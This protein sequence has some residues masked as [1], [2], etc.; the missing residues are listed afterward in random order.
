MYFSLNSLPG[1]GAMWLT[2]IA[3]ARPLVVWLCLIA[4]MLVGIVS[5]YQLPVELN[6]R[7]T[8]PTITVV[9]AYPGAGPSEVEK[10][11]SKPIEDVVRGLNGVK[12]IYSSS[13][14]NI[15][16]VS[17]DF[18]VGTDIPS[19][20]RDLQSRIDTL[21]SQFPTSVQY[22]VVA[23]LDINTQP[24][25]TLGVSSS[26]L[27]V[28]QL[29]MLVKK[30]VVPKLQ[31]IQ[32]IGKIT[33]LGGAD[34]EVSVSVSPNSLAQN[35]LTI[36]DV[37]NSLDA[38]GIN[39]P[40][41]NIN[42]GEATTD[43][44]MQD[45][46][47]S[48]SQINEAPVF[49]QSLA[50]S[51][52]ASLM[53]PTPT[54]AE[55]PAPPL[56]VGDLAR[57]SLSWGKPASIVAIDGKPGISIVISKSS[58]S[59]AVEVADNV[60]KVMNSI[61]PSLHNQATI[62][63]LNNSTTIVRAAL[64]DVDFSLI[65]GALLSMGVVY[66]FL[67]NARG[68]VIV[69][70]AI[71]ACVAATFTMMQV[72]HLTL[73]QMTLLALSL[74]VGILIDDSIVVLEA[75]TRHLN[76]G[77]SP[78]TAALNG[79]QEIGFAGMTITLV[80]VVVFI[81]IA[82]MGGIV[83]GFF[84]QFGLCIATATLFS[85]LIAFTVTPVLASL[86]YSEN[87]LARTNTRFQ[88][89]F[90]LLYVKVER[91]YRHL[92]RFALSHRG[93]VV[94]SVV[95]VLGVICYFSVANLGFDFIPGIDQGEVQV[96]IEMPAGSSMQNTKTE[97]DTIVKEIST[98]SQVHT[99]VSTVGE[100]VGG[101]GVIP[102]NGSQYGQILVQL[103]PSA[104]II[105]KLFSLHSNKARIQ[106]DEDVAAKIR[107]LLIPFSTSGMRITVSA[108]RS[109]I[110]LSSPVDIELRGPDYSQLIAY[111]A[112]VRNVLAGM[113]T[114]LNPDV[115]VRGGRPEVQALINPLRA[116]MYHIPP[117]Q[118]GQILREAVD[119]AGAG[120]LQTPDKAIT[121]R[122]HLAG[123][124]QNSPLSIGSIQV[125][126]DSKNQP[127]Q[128]S[129]I[130]D[131]QSVMGPAN[132]ERSD[133]QR[134][135]EV[136]GDLAPSAHLGNVEA[137][138]QSRIS[139]IAHP[140]I[141]IHWSGDAEALNDNALPFVMSLGLAALLVYLVVATLFNSI[142]TPLV[143]LSVLPMALV[144]G[145]AA[146]AITG[147]A[148]SLVAAIGIIMLCGLMGRNAILLL[149]NTLTHI[150]NG[151]GTNEALEEAGAIRLRPILMTTIAT[152]MGMLPIALRIGQASEIRAPMATVVIGGLLLSTLLTLVM[153]PIIFSL[154]SDSKNAVSRWLHPDKKQ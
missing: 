132:I 100:I 28:D 5:Y 3:I 124:Q 125:G 80:D 60:K 69:A 129:D 1:V 42:Q 88:T 76:M 79:R 21:R 97:T 131:I 145:F 59:G 93:E 4:T 9:T 139:S 40:A 14:S 138:V 44:R 105:E 137:A 30:E 143:I 154:F 7:V 120:S 58:T 121:I 16:I 96:N 109:V 25:M 77:E 41:G 10:Q 72:L 11:I 84:R 117:T 66:F 51:S 146:L 149:D 150:K 39:I 17:I 95:V 6:P 133:G 8:I 62:R 46:Y 122:V 116:D 82:F 63:I 47:D 111:A 26:T 140:G 90:E 67:H 136:T 22:P 92:I 113:K 31:S 32:G 55:P 27:Q 91:V 128:L 107:R 74:S 52:V 70:I 29:R 127:I 123:I 118:A 110:G 108:L 75:I 112:K 2:R 24:I 34:P 37:I 147:E 114:V 152:I 153:I 57:V 49:S 15:S 73:N 50:A 45:N 103:K 71:P 89:T 130:A 106:S 126:S 101:F 86:W 85:L 65:L 53:R 142:S 54:N 151:M 134:L 135:I 43:I 33:L 94:L 68:T 104:G 83:G 87:R 19:V 64:D 102:R 61:N 20:E 119:G 36:L 78:V 38:G 48:L 18:H 13:Q 144:G 98:V 99:T 35:G 81:P 56:T 23:P 148:L 12:N 115:S 141:T